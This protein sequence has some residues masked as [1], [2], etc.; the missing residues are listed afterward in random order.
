MAVEL[1]NSEGQIQWSRFNA[2]LVVNSV[3]L[4]FTGLAFSDNSLGLHIAVPKT[5]PP[6]LGL[7]FCYLW[8]KMTKNGF[9]WIN[10]W[11]SEARKLEKIL[12]NSVNPIIEGNTKR[13]IRKEV[14]NTAYAAYFIIGIIAFL[15]FVIL[16]GV[17]N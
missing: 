17:V 5:I 15:Y 9:Y 13:E 14:I 12:K 7:L 3:F 1:H 11:L 8:F 2:M 4:A 10:H 6:L 16:I